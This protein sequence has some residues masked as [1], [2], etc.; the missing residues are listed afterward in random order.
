MPDAPTPRWTEADSATF[1]DIADVA[2]PGRREQ[3]D[4]LLSLIPAAEDDA[5]LT[6]DLACGEGLFSERVLE[7]FPR[8]RVVAFDGSDTM[9]AQATARLARFGERAEVRPFALE[10]PDWLAAITSPLR[11]AVSS[12]CFH[13]LDAAAKRRLFCDLAA[14]LEPGGALLIADVVAPASD[15]VRRSW[16]ATWDEIARRQSIELTGT[17][18]A[19]HTFVEDGWNSHA[20]TE[21]EPGEMPSR[22]YDQLKWLEE[23]GFS[24]VDCLWMRAGFAVYGG[25][26]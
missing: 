23:A 6:A 11:C 16:A 20:L 3:M 15:L 4:V 21:P 7:R 17:T 8:S 5:F 22:L 10:N 2:V 26:R 19:Y 12:L 13:H 18:D 25:Y 9:L 14:R 1:L 24:T